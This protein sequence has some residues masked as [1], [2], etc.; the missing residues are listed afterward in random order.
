[1]YEYPTYSGQVIELAVHK[2]P[3]LSILQ[4]G[5]AASELTSSILS[6]VGA[7]SNSPKLFSKF[8][9][10]DRDSKAIERVEELFQDRKP[11]LNFKV[12]NNNLELEASQYLDHSVDIIIISTDINST[13]DGKR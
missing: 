10:A 2:N 12:L 9:L 3:E 1:M 5:R 8:T 4:V 7:H 6:V 13:T 11:N